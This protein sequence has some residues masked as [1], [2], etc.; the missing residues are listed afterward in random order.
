MLANT[1]GL[2]DLAYR[3]ARDDCWGLMIRFYKLN[4]DID[5]PNYARPN[6]W[7]TKAPE[8]DITRTHFQKAG[9]EIVHVHRRE[10]K[11][12][13]LILMNIST[14]VI[15]HTA[16]YIGVGK[17]LHHPFRMRSRVDLYGGVWL[18]RTM[19]VGRHP[20]VPQHVARPEIDL[21]DLLP[22]AKREKYRAILA[23]L[24]K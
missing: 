16:A 18:D 12:G 11:A 1:E 3:E 8:L 19:L 24:N 14:A 23:N 13:D 10:L 4:Y 21:M 7:W 5:L 22:P 17:I 2:T 9:F 15:D 6:L 20:E